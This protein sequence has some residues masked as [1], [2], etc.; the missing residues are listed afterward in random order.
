MS[1]TLVRYVL[2]TYAVLFAGIF[3]AML[4]IYLVVDF[5]DRAKVYTSQGWI[6]EIAL[7]YAYK[8][9]MVAQ[10]LSPAV[11]LLAAAVAVSMLRKRG[12]L[13]ALG[14]L[15][16]GPSVLYVPVAALATVIAVAFIGFDEWL[17]VDASR[18]VDELHTQR[19][20]TW[21]DWRLYHTPKQWFRSGDRIFCLRSGDVDSGFGDVTILTVT[22][23]FDLA[24]RLDARRMESMG[25][26]IWRLTDVVRRDF[27]PDGS[28]V[29]S[30]QEVAQLDLGLDRAALRILPG[31]PQQMHFQE[32]RKQIE[33]RRRSGHSTAQYDL[34]LHN[35]F[36]Y[37]L[38][39]VPAA[40]VAVGLALR[41]GRKGHLTVAMVEGL[42]V[43]MTLWVMMVIARTMVLTGRLP[44][45][46]AA[47]SPLGIL[48]VLAA[49]LWLRHEGW[50]GG[51]GP[52]RASPGAA[53]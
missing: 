17:V 18:R 40:L 2:R 20:D 47:W 12:E 53:G 5:V 52:R 36:A 29:L 34:A 23:D 22:P 42:A 32:L 50:F 24:Q 7:V 11:L 4:A 16:F 26:R 38:A 37:P 39:G 35:R 25:D 28:S 33:A 8:A 45:G 14:A 27:R 13:T 49:F 6:W 44:P 43:V 31:R 3:F 15:S 30:Q 46:A 41:R 10:Q 19:F 9:E 21:G 1:R 51:R 48:A